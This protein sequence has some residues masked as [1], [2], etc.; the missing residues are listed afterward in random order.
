[1]TISRSQ[2][3]SMIKGTLDQ[4]QH[5]D[6]EYDNKTHRNSQ[7][8]YLGKHPLHRVTHPNPNVH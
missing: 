3:Q 1:M 2:L 8:Y 7:P 4:S 5:L 6:P